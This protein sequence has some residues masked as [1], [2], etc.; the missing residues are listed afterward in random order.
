MGFG[1]RISLKLLFNRAIAEHHAN[2][3]LANLAEELGEHFAGLFFVLHK[4]I[5]LGVGFHA[6]RNAQGF[7]LGQIFN[8]IFGDRAKE[9]IAIDFVLGLI[10]KDGA[11]ALGI[12]FNLGDWLF[13]KFSPERFAQFFAKRL[14]GLGSH[15]DQFALVIAQLAPIA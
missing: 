5:A 13:S 12:V 9:Q 15:F 1:V 6:N 8:P 11:N 7:H 3:A 10:A 2:H 4:R 14:T